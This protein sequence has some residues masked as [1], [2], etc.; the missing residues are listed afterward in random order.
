[1]AS[2]A[3]LTTSTSCSRA[4]STS[5]PCSPTR[6][7]STSGGRPSPPSP[8][9]ARPAPSRSPSTTVDGRRRAGPPAPPRRGER[10]L[11]RLPALARVRGLGEAV[12]VCGLARAR[13]RRPH[14][15]RQRAEA[16][17]PALPPGSLRLLLGPVGE[18]VLD[19]SG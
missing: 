10:R 14:P 18:G 9:R 3:S 19:R 12:A 13:R 2:T 11:L 15:V 4:G 5:R 7:H 1:S 17:D 6:S 16:L 8:A